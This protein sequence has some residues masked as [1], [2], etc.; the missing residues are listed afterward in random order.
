[1]LVKFKLIIAK[2]RWGGVSPSINWVK[3]FK[4][5]I[6]NSNFYILGLID[7]WTDRYTDIYIQIYIQIDIQIYIQLD[8]QKYMYTDIKTY[9]YT[10]E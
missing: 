10:E 2:K 4:I 8:I 6:Q 1:M 9:R 3:Q 5:E 7:I